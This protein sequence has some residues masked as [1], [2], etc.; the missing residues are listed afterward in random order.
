MDSFP[1][2]LMGVLGSPDTKTAAPANTTLYAPATAGATSISTVA[3]I[4]AG[5]YVVIAGGSPGTIETHVTGTPSTSGSP[6]TIPLVFPLIYSQLSGATVT[7]LTK[8]QFSLLNNSP[9][10][11]NQPPSFTISDFGGETSWRQLTSSQL[12][13]INLT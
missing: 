1:L 3:S 4:P 11:G 2:L 9:S 12:D 6:Y 7:G 8:H 5:S 10:T 13:G